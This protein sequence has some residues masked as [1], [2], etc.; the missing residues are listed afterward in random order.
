MLQKINVRKFAVGYNV[1]SWA[2]PYLLYMKEI[3]IWASFGFQEKELLLWKKKVKREAR[4]SI[5]AD[6]I[7]WREWVYIEV[8]KLLGM[9]LGSLF[10]LN[11]SLL[12]QYPQSFCLN[13]MFVTSF[14]WWHQ[15]PQVLSIFIRVSL[16][17][18]FWITSFILCANITYPN[19]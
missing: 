2:Y 12:F 5:A 19:N 16:P 10:S 6:E 4:D 14:S 1:K 11:S 7:K 17:T 13:P 8:M 18:L 15:L 9:K 3:M